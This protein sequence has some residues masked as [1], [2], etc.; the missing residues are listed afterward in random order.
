MTQGPGLTQLGTALTVAV[1]AKM[2]MVVFA[3]ETALSDHDG[4]QQMDQAK[5]V[6]ATGAGFVPI[7]TAAGAEDA[8]RQAFYQ[9]RIESRPIVLNAPMDV[10]AENYDGDIDE[11]EPSTTLLPGL[12][13]VQPDPDRLREAIRVIS[14]SQKPVIVAGHGAA[15]ADAGEA[16]HEA[17]RSD[18]GAAGDHAADEGLARRVG[19]PRRRLRP[20]RH[21]DGHRAVRGG[22]RASSAWAPA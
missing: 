13:R 3:G 18:R 8:V 5:F 1:R 2:P 12:Q 15:K 20:V 7:W 10:Q 14:E 16:D 17:G 9:A 11:Y 6:D 22:G 19:V 4:V 21:Q